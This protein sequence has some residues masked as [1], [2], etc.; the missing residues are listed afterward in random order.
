[1]SPSD[2]KQMQSSQEKNGYIKRPMN[3]FMVWCHIHRH[4]LRKTCPEA[5]MIDT[6]IQLGCEWS[7]LSE[8]QKTPYYEV[9]YKL[10]AMHKQQFPGN[11]T[12]KWQ[13]LIVTRG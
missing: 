8:E 9:A 12:A 13:Q 3:A 2:L 4:A 7:K 11:Y 5:N 1:M 10:K 6:S